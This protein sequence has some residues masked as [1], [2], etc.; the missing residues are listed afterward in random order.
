MN[1]AG[2]RYTVWG[3]ENNC[4]H[5]AYG[6]GHSG[7]YWIVVVLNGLA[8]KQRPTI[9]WGRKNI[10]SMQAFERIRLIRKCCQNVFEKCHKVR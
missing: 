3:N 5:A 10:A 4:A 1:G 7:P 2:L 6:F 9:L 8:A